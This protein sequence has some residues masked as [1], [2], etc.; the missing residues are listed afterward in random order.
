MDSQ[1]KRRKSDNFSLYKNNDFLFKEKERIVI[2]LMITSII[3]YLFFDASSLNSDKKFI[4]VLCL[5]VNI[6]YGVINIVRYLLVNTY[7]KQIYTNL[8]LYLDIV[9]LSLSL[10]VTPEKSQII[11]TI[12]LF[13][14]ISTGMNY[15][16][17]AMLKSNSLVIALFTCAVLVNGYWQENMTATFSFY[18]TVL[19]I[20]FYL[21]SIIKNIEINA[22]NL[23]EKAYKDHLTGLYN[24]TTINKKLE[25]VIAATK[26]TNVMSALF[27]F[28]LD[29][30]K[31]VNDELGHKAGDYLLVAIAA[32]L[33]KTFRNKDLIFR[34]GGDEFLVIAEGV[35]TKE[36]AEIIANKILEAVVESAQQLR[37]PINVTSSLGIKCIKPEDVDSV[38]NIKT[39]ITLADQAMYEAKKAGK[40]QYVFSG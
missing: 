16:Y 23:N 4:L 20:P 27:Y 17:K 25:K 36:D 38:D 7:K 22:Y 31:K 24:R 6:A 29:N 9:F 1:K 37:I 35:W 3:S 12:I 14:V 10:F 40:S 19:L 21:T 13:L 30:F 33:K 11:N 8:F 32:N 39:Y 34:L 28:D 2:R 15:G 26:K 18:L 5:F